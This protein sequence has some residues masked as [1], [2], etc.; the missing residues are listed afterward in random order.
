MATMV[1]LPGGQFQMGTDEADLER[2]ARVFGVRRRELF[3][4]EVPRHG[5]R[6]DPFWLDAYPVT[7]AEFQRFVAA[8]PE[9]APDRI[10]ARYD[11]GRYLQHWRG[12]AHP[13]DLAEHPVVNASWYAAMA[14]ARWAGKR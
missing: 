1:C 14:Y 8:A 11:N 10:P 7:N 12:A 5:V 2:L 4:P 6:V 9:W 13:P 3:A